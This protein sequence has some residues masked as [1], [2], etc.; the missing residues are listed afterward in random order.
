MPPKKKPSRKQ[1][2]Q[3]EDPVTQNDD[4]EQEVDAPPPG[5]AGASETPE[6]KQVRW[7]KPKTTWIAQSTYSKWAP[8]LFERS[9]KELQ[10]LNTTSFDGPHLSS[11]LCQEEA[12]KGKPSV[13][14]NDSQHLQSLYENVE[15]RRED[16]LNEIEDEDVCLLDIGLD[17]PIPLVGDR[18]DG[19]LTATFQLENGDEHIASV[20]ILRRNLNEETPA[21]HFIVVPLNNTVIVNGTTYTNNVPGESNRIFIGPLGSFSI[22]ELLHTPIFL[23]KNKEGALSKAKGKALKRSKPKGEE[24]PAATLSFDIIPTREDGLGQPS[25]GE[26]ESDDS[27]SSDKPD[28]GGPNSNA[29]HSDRPSI[30]RPIIHNGSDKIPSQHSSSSDADSEE[31]VEVP[32]ETEGSYNSATNLED[33]VNPVLLAISRLQQDRNTGFC[34]EINNTLIR[35]GQPWILPLR[36]ARATV[37]LVLHCVRSHKSSG[38]LDMKIRVLNP[39]ESKSNKQTR[40]YIWNVASGSSVLQRWMAGIGFNLQELQIALPD[41]LES[42]PSPAALDE[43]EASMITILNAWTVA[44]G[45]ELNPNWV[46]HHY[47]RNSSA[48]TKADRVRFFQEARKLFDLALSGHR[49][50]WR[51]V[52]GFLGNQNYVVGKRFLERNRMFSLNNVSA[53]RLIETQM[54]AQ[55]KHDNMIKRL[56]QETNDN[57]EKARSVSLRRTTLVKI[58]LHKSPSKPPSLKRL[59]F[60][61]PSEYPR[62]RIKSLPDDWKK[63]V[64]HLTLDEYKV[65]AQK[66]KKLEYEGPQNFPQKEHPPKRIPSLS[67][68]DAKYRVFR[69]TSDFPEEQD[70]CTYL[71]KRMMQLVDEPEEEPGSDID[72]PWEDIDMKQTVRSIAS[73][74]QAV[75]HAEGQVRDLESIDY[76]AIEPTEDAVSRTIKYSGRRLLILPTITMNRKG[77]PA[78]GVAKRL[79]LVTIQ[80]LHTGI[81]MRWRRDVP[82][83]DGVYVAKE[84][85]EPEPVSVSVFEYAPWYSNLEERRMTYA[86][87]RRFIN[88]NLIGPNQIDLGENI[89]WYAGP[90]L[91]DISSGWKFKH[92]VILHAWALALGLEVNTDFPPQGED[93]FS[94]ANTLIGLVLKGLADWKLVWSFLRCH[95]FVK[96]TKMVPKER[97]FD[98]TVAERLLKASQSR[99]SDEAHELLPARIPRNE[100][101]QDV[102]AGRK[103]KHDS[104]FPTDSWQGK[105]EF[106]EAMQDLIKVGIRVSDLTRTQLHAKHHLFSHQEDSPSDRNPGAQDTEIQIQDEYGT[107]FV[108]PDPCKDFKEEL[109]SLIEKH[110]VA[111]ADVAKTFRS[112]EVWLK[113]DDAGRAIASVTLAITSANDLDHGYSYISA[114]E[115]EFISEAVESTSDP[116]MQKAHLQLLNLD[117]ATPG[118]GPIIVALRHGNHIVLMILQLDHHSNPEILVLDSR[119]WSWDQAARNQVYQI[120]V[121]I[122][123][124]ASWEEHGSSVSLEDPPH[125]KWVECATQ[126]NSWACGFYTAFNGWAA[127]LGLVINPRF[128]KNWNKDNFEFLQEAAE[129]VSLVVMGKATLTLIKNFLDYSKFVLPGQTIKK[130]R[131]FRHTVLNLSRFGSDLQDLLNKLKVKEDVYRR[132]GR[133]SHNRIDLPNSRPHNT[134]WPCDSWEE[135]S[136]EQYLFMLEDLAKA[137]HLTP[138]MNNWQL[139]NAFSKYSTDWITAERSI[140]QRFVTD[141][142]MSQKPGKTMTSP[143]LVRKFQKYSEIDN[144]ELQ[145]ID[146]SPCIISS[147]N[148]G[149]YQ[150][151]VDDARFDKRGHIQAAVSTNMMMDWSERVACIAA[152]VQAIDVHQTNIIGGFSLVTMRSI[153]SAQSLPEDGSGV[154]NALD[155]L[156]ADDSNRLDPVSR[157]RRC[158]LLPYE[159]SEILNMRSVSHSFLAVIQEEEVKRGGPNRFCVYFLDSR[160][161]YLKVKKDLIYDQI[162]HMA[163]ALGWAIQRNG[164]GDIDFQAS[165]RFVK[166]TN[167]GTPFACGDHTVLNAW[168]LALGL[169]PSLHGKSNLTGNKYEKTLQELRQLMN[170]ALNGALDWKTLT[171]WLFCNRLTVET[172]AGLVPPNRRFNTTAAQITIND[173]G[174]TNLHEYIESLRSE[175]EMM[176]NLYQDIP[177]DHTSNVDFSRDGWEFEYEDG[178]GPQE[179]NRLDEDMD[180]LGFLDFGPDMPYYRE[181]A[182]RQWQERKYQERRAHRSRWQQKMRDQQ[183]PPG[184]RRRGLSFL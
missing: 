38:G 70:P 48:S 179:L 71:R 99:L 111:V 21:E 78:R 118:F 68:S 63:T 151:L 26:G 45:L 106:E 40:D 109:K 24:Q 131:R 107:G 56:R 41:S 158:W 101:F 61:A 127:A 167:Q 14:R 159:V 96:N 129:V 114:E 17:S 163:R 57:Q 149:F 169:T 77:A 157:P 18:M 34:V 122:M 171:A 52:Y 43:E 140:P 120:A 75:A 60:S 162:K 154:S 35:P 11:P 142:W 6:I 183:R 148:R 23:W 64:P 92:Y 50:S 79:I 72:Y 49:L 137:G 66:R 93:F 8:A 126:T 37:L 112:E 65:Y 76:T 73:V 161:Q 178:H 15:L 44:L 146:I 5:E 97:R 46:P 152:V 86:E 170:L 124:K 135:K 33:V 174:E 121:Q 39:L 28:N 160:P 177:Y 47:P 119:A 130:G 102:V 55:K 22:I 94:D 143:G 2:S 100:G 103:R 85:S 1:P 36:L 89:N 12:G 90:I 144:L 27:L 10:R 176:V 67:W 84:V 136:D 133:M 113:V 82:N 123:R 69:D 19:N 155:L 4:A 172:R 30:D 156:Q 115:A 153:E 184:I 104:E 141:F 58:E 20:E 181:Q 132:S 91:P 9:W 173:E 105:E 7:A 25:R 31:P 125:A 54:D 108:S 147:R 81:A 110:G 74:V 83:S 139:K 88:N 138:N 165:P 32:Q 166:V 168:I 95:N 134:D 53:E 16:Y 117:A 128:L 80:P 29:P 175:D 182:E 87:L 116:E 42:V 145:G 13:P 62:K 51:H 150:L 164:A 3:K 59:S 180:D 98:H